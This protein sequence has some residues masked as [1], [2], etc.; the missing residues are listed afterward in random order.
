MLRIGTVPFLVARPLTAGL[1]EDPEVQ[2]DTAVPARLAEGLAAGRLDVAL[3]SSVLVLRR[4]G[5]RLWEEGPV[6]ACRKAVR[7]VLLFLRPGLG[8]P[9][10]VRRLLTDPASRTGSALARIVLRDRF[11]ADFRA[12]EAAPGADPFGQGADAVQLIGDAALRAAAERS[13]WR[14]L[15]LGETWVALTR[16]PFVFAGWICRPGFDPAR[17]AGV[18]EAAAE[19]GLAARERLAREAAHE[20]GLSLD[21]LVRYLTED[22]AW[23]L[24]PR[25]LR[26]SLEEFRRRLARLESGLLPPAAELSESR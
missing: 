3:A 11:Q 13:D 5:Y 16:L 8:G 4:P 24:P 21:F 25:E 17:A 7:S 19:R 23:R 2:L 6:I 18:L 20:T 12:E 26:A 22:V 15:D 9:E 14:P 1:A 10:H